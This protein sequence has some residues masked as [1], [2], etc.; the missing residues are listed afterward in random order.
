MG[1]LA[2]ILLKNDMRKNYFLFVLLLVLVGASCKWKAKDGLNWDQNLVAPIVK[3]RIGLGDAI[4]DASFVQTNSDNSITVV[5]RD[6]LVS[7]KLEDYL[8]VPD[9][10]YGAKITLSTIALATDTLTQDITMGQ[11]L[12][13][14]CDQGQS[15]AC[16][17]YAQQGQTIFLIPALSNLSSDDVPID[18]SQFFDEADL[19]TGW[20]V[21]EVENRLPLD[22]GSVTF[23]LRN[24][25]LLS[26]TL[27]RKTML[28]INS[29]Q[30]KR[31]SA[32]L[33][34]KTVGKVW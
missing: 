27:V 16:S 13:Q 12:R 31:D 26:D 29:G 15:I 24:A 10:A 5:F 7:L 20:M 14:L 17:L 6:T 2:S 3:S 4:K 9:T 30:T 11:I 21:V 32:D 18:A 19:L 28:N 33:A 34:G 1:L 8:V 22:I 25:G 23:H